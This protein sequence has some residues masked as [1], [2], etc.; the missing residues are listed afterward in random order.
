EHGGVEWRRVR[1]AA[2]FAFADIVFQL[3]SSRIGALI[4]EVGGICVV[5]AAAVAKHVSVMEGIRNHRT[6]AVLAGSTQVVET[7]QVAALA[8]PV[9]NG[10]IH[11]CQFRLL[12]EILNWKY[13][14]E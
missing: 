2:L 11:E 1:L 8:F 13:R 12:A 4:A 7:L 14:L 5:R 6:A 10:I 3:Q 9:A